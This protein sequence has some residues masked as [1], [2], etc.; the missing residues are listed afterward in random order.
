MSNRLEEN[1]SP[2]DLLNGLDKRPSRRAVISQMFTVGC[3]LAMSLCVL[4]LFFLLARIF[5]DGWERVSLAFITGEASPYPEDAG[6]KIAL[7][8]SLC[9]ILLTSAI[10][11]PIGIG[12]AL[13]LEEYAA[14]SKIRK[15]IQLNISNLAGVPSIVYGLLGLTIFVRSFGLKQSLLSGALTLALVILPIIIMASQEAL[16][17][18]PNSIRQASYALGATRWQTVWRQ[19]L[20]AA[21]PGMMTGVILAISRALGE[22][23]PILAI[24]AKVYISYAPRTITVTVGSTAYDTYIPVPGT[25]ME[26]FAAMPLQIYSWIGRPQ[27]EFHSVAAAG[28]IVLLAV[29]ILMNLGGVLIRYHFGKKIRW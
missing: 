23:A 6:I 15:I 27:E 26:E 7:I 21:L 5:M 8:G 28:I 13:Y 25:V 4:I 14:K 2:N 24:G 22:A 16:R 3:F 18:V 1:N 9:L 11:V 17:A 10:A 12:A 29:L 19:V 20:P